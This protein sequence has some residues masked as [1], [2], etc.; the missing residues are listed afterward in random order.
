MWAADKGIDL[1][2]IDKESRTFELLNNR[3][4][5]Y[6]RQV[7][8]VNEFISELDKKPLSS[9]SIEALYD[10]AQD[11]RSMDNSATKG[12]ANAIEKEIGQKA[13]KEQAEFLRKAGKKQGYEYNVPGENGVPQEDLTNYRAW[14][15]SNNMTSKRPEIQ[16]LINET[17]KQYREYLV[18]FKKY[19][20]IIEKSNDSLVRS[21]RKNL[22]IMKRI[23]R[24]FNSYDR[25]KHIYG[26]L[27]S[28]SGDKVR[29]LNKE[30]ITEKWD[31]LSK[32]EQEYWTN[33]MTIAK[34]LIGA[35][36]SNGMN[37][38]G[39]QMGNL[40]AVSKNGL[41]GLYNSTIDSFDYQR[42][43]VYGTDVD[44]KRVLK[45]FYEW[46]NDVYKG[47]TGK[48]TLASGKQILELD[49]L[50]KKAQQLKKLG[51][52]ED[53][54]LIQLSDNEYDA[55]VNNGYRL[56]QMVGHEPSEIDAELIRE[57]DMRQGI[58]LEDG[59]LNINTALM[60]FIRSSLFMHGENTDITPN[61]FKGMGHIS[62]LTDSIIAFNKGLDNENA[63]KY[64]TKWWKEGFLEKKKQDSIFGKRA[65]KVIDGFVRL[66]SLRLLGFNISVG[67]GN[68]LAGKYQELRKRGG[69]QFITGEARF[70]KD[71]SKSRA[72]LKKHR[73]I[74]HSFDEFVHLS[75]K[76]G[77]W[78]K[79]EKATFVFMDQSEHYIQGSAFLGMLTKEEFNSGEVSDQR[80]MYINHK[81]STLHGE[82]YSSFDASMLSMYS[83]GRALLQ[84][85]KWFITLM[86][87]R[88]SAEEI[89][90][91]GKVSIGS[92]RAAGEF[93]NSTMRDLFSGKIKMKDIINIYNNSSKHRQEEIQ[94]YLRGVGIGLTLLALIAMMEDDDE[95]DTKTLRNLKKLSHDIFVTTDVNRFVNYTAVPSSLSTLKN[96][97]RGIHEAV[98]EDK[99]KR[100][101]PYGEAG[102]SKAMKTFNFEVGPYAEIRKDIANTFYSGPK[103]KKK[104]S[105]LIR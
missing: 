1:N 22:T 9:Y 32:E 88:F 2:K 65:D 85:K 12:L 49:K 98:R 20:D 46:K 77:A 54:S 78:G 17:Q 74:E 39:M 45:S 23:G 25:Y 96:A 8:L 47:R 80:V 19:K 101:G 64:L 66:T 70:W 97:S 26:N 99:I 104:S 21:K 50:K 58:K 7:E 86:Q 35:E 72:I 76:K 83:Y 38:P 30:E 84:F 33:Y 71:W 40:E 67:V 42:V 60:E 18:S 4:I 82:G 36:E 61:G 94:N 56:K 79:I 93:A 100:S 3:F 63:V 16:Y 52:H 41:F 13:F 31:S 53:G 14:L 48:I 28:I 10:I 102:S 57:Y 59:T 89:D 91:F 73:I 34:M 103:E 68:I 62:I 44:G 27:I 92:Y 43:K 105:S 29:M 95:P 24:S 81:I 5:S 75:E 69:K 15:G 11:F 90:R 37:I 51:K 6:Q 55:L 87:D